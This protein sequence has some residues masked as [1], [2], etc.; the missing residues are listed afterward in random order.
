M[1]TIEKI[2]VMQAYVDGKQVQVRITKEEWAD[3]SRVSEPTWN[4]SNN[5]YR[6][7]PEPKEP[8]Y[9]PYKDFAE[10]RKE[11]EK[12][13]GW[14]RVKGKEDYIHFIW[15]NR[16]HSEH[17]YEKYVWADDKTPCGIKEED[18]IKAIKK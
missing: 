16:M 13:G 7:K 3:M 6:I 15:F 14:M 2:A 4:W 9:R 8:T 10:F 12:H 17:I 11:W 1:T 18:V 5:E